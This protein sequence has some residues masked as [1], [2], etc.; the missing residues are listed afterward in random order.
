MK[1]QRQATPIQVDFGWLNPYPYDFHKR[2]DTK[3]ND[4][5]TYI[6]TTLP[7]AKTML[8]AFVMRDVIHPP[9][10][11]M[12]DAGNGIFKKHQYAYSKSFHDGRRH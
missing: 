6:F 8:S 2:N 3:Q 9:I 7:L 4:N 1:E 12:L 11:W 5:R 10:Q